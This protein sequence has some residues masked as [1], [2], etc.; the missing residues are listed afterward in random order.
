MQ[1]TLNTHKTNRGNY[2]NPMTKYSFLFSQMNKND[3][4]DLVKKTKNHKIR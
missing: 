2:S 3:N 1:S 4:F